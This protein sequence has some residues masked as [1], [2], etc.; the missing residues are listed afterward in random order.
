MTF[1]A[2]TQATAGVI[3]SPYGDTRAYIINPARPSRLLPVGAVGELCLSGNQV[4]RG[5]L[6][7]ADITAATFVPDPFAPGLTMYRSGDRARWTSDG[8]IEYLGRQDDAFVKLRGLRIDTGEVEDAITGAGDTFA[9][10]ELLEL[11]DQPHLVGFISRTLAPTGEA[12]LALAFDPESGEEKTTNDPLRV[13]RRRCAVLPPGRSRV[14]D[15][16]SL[17][18]P[19]CHAA[20]REQQV[21]QKAVARVLP[22]TRRCTRRDILRDPDANARPARRGIHAGACD[23][24]CVVQRSR[25]RR[26]RRRREFVGARRLLRARRRLDR[27]RADAFW[28]ESVEDGDLAQGDLD[29]PYDR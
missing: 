21:R 23:C 22:E 6:N 24:A 14:R 27:R 26:G 1:T 16:H 19:A 25:T 9:V 18:C 28:P 5:Y 13:A 11:R 10:V 2:T 12:D 29:W 20:E 15:P 8:F 17:A 4:G 7:R 3:G